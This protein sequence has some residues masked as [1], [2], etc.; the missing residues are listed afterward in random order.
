M[1]RVLYTIGHSS[2]TADE[3]LTLLRRE[4]VN[5]IV[6]VRSQP[7]ARYFPQ[8]NQDR[9]TDWLRKAGVLYLSFCREFTPRQYDCL[10]PDG[11]VDFE[12][13]ARKAPFLQAAARIERGMALGYRIALM[14][15]EGDPYKCH[16][17]CFLGRHFHEQ[18]VSVLHYGP[19]GGLATHR[20]LQDRMVRKYL[21]KSRIPAVTSLFET[22]SEADQIAAAYRVKNRE[23]GFQTSTGEDG[24]L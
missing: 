18:G 1:E 6:D 8:F 4:H 21:R 14:C 3:F 23:I 9:L 5:C 22:F 7:Q 15:S 20:E 13:A 10:T 24:F 16:R 11:Q 2:H 12:Q 19:H 17:F